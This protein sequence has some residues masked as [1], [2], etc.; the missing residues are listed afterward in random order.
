MHILV[1]QNHMHTLG[2]SETATYA[3]VSALFR[4]GHQVDLFTLHPGLVSGRLEAEGACRVN[5]LRPSYDAL[6]LQHNTT[7][8][9]LEARGI[10]GPRLQ[11]CHGTW[12]WEERPYPGMD[13]YIAISQEVKWYLAGRGHQS[14]VVWNGVD[15]AYYAP[16]RA[17]RRRPRVIFSLAQSAEAHEMIGRAAR[18]LGAEHRYRDKNANP[19]F[20]FR[21]EM[22]DADLVFGLGRS[23]YEAM[24]FGKAVFVFD[25]RIYIGNKGDGMLT[26]ER[27]D[28]LMSCNCSGRAM[29]R[30]Y[31]AR[32]LAEEIDRDYH[33]SLGEQNRAFALRYLNIDRQAGRYLEALGLAATAPPLR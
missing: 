15:C 20:D 27:T 7:I 3:L 14:Q 5:R 1:S 16:L 24:A 10:E 32:R 26:P 29:G 21:S 19:V 22:A 8:P 4:A 13:K 23:A 2:G 33:E 9:I 18:L 17:I 30:V 28:L 6:L 25:I 11:I 12:P 31:T